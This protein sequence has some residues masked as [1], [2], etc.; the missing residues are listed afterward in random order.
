MLT[1]KGH[2]LIRDDSTP[3]NTHPMM[4][5]T[6]SQV[7]AAAFATILAMV[8]ASTV[9]AQAHK[10]HHAGMHRAAGQNTAK[11]AQQAKAA[12]QPANPTTHPQA[13]TTT[14]QKSTASPASG[15]HQ[16]NPST[17]KPRPSNAALVSALHSARTQ[18]AQTTHDYKGHRARAMQ[19]VGAA[20]KF[21][22]NQGGRS[23]A[24]N[25]NANGTTQASRSGTAAGTNPATGNSTRTAASTSTRT[26]TG[27]ATGQGMSQGASDAQLRQAQQ[28]LQSIESQMD[29]SGMNP[30]GFVQAKSSLQNAIR[31]LNLALND[32]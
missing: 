15:T 16:N 5:I 7:R 29:S 1:M 10:G 22:A 2:D 24:A 31:E 17:N 18:L 28:A 26:G 14:S 9:F 3:G 6:L 30:H 32:L 13:S 27:S 20:I 23:I 4:S 19:E 12:N 8:P 25:A 21:L 11:T